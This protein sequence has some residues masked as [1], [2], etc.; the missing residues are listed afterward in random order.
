MEKDDDIIALLSVFDGIRKQIV[1]QDTYKITFF[2]ELDL[3]T[4]HNCSV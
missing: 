3:F 1:L 4:L 2:C